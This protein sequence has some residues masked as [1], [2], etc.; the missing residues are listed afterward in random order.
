MLCS[1][2]FGYGVSNLDAYYGSFP[3]IGYVWDVNVVVHELGHNFGSPHTHCYVPPIDHCYNE[4]AGC[5]A[6]PVEPT[7][8]ETMSYCHLVDMIEQGFGNVVTT[9][10]RSNAEAAMCIGAAPG[11]C[12]DGV[13]DEGEACDDANTLDGDCCASNCAAEAGAPCTDDADPC[14]TD[15]CNEAGVCAHEPPGT[16][17]PCDVPTLVPPA[18]GTFMGSTSGTSTV[19][20][21]CGGS[22]AERAY[23][24][25]PAVAGVA[26]IAT[27]GSGFDTVL[28]VHTGTCASG[29]AVACNDDGSC[30]VASE[31]S[32]A[33]SAG[34]TYYLFV[35]GFG[36]AAGAYALAIDVL[37]L[38]TCSAVPLGACKLPT[39]SGKASLQLKDA[40]DDTKDQLQWKWG[41]GA[42]TSMAD[43]GSPDASDFYQLCLYANGSLATSAAVPPGGTCG[44]K[45]CWTAKPTSFAYKNKSRAPHGI[46]QLQ[47]KS[48]PTPGKAKIGLKGKGSQLTMPV[49]GSLTPPLRVQ[50][51]R[52]GGPCWEAAYGAPVVKPDGSQLKAKSD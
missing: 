30:G 43:L 49:L 20:G 31:L 47:L 22:G 44:T 1:D 36:G 18:G 52:P 29:P 46:E 33:V 42:A 21:A 11:T 9:L 28:H 8:G 25:T 39:Q 16:C 51:V 12:G 5:Y 38:P 19:T 32:F 6:G 17:L 10:I 7:I 40:G 35:D 14:T 50:L 34:T 41:S 23:T 24:W 3:T 15:A 37:P 13:L 2:T 45:P 27:C 4:E 26:Q 48:S